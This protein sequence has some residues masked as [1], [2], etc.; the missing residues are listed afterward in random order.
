M[1]REKDYSMIETR[2][3]KNVVIFSQTILSSVLPRKITNIYND[4]HGNISLIFSLFSQF[5][6]FISQFSLIVLEQQ[7]KTG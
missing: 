4:I 2:R 3:L 1:S 7:N 6:Q 5:S